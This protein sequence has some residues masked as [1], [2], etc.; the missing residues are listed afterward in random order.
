MVGDWQEGLVFEAVQDR[1]TNV[2]PRR[3]ST[4]H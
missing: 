2:A 3:A 1:L 4:L